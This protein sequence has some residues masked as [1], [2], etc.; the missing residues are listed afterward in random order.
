MVK[1]DTGLQLLVTCWYY[2]SVI[3]S[4]LPC[5]ISPNVVRQ[6]CP[7]STSTAWPAARHAAARTGVLPEEAEYLAGVHD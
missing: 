5:S 2:L 7:G 6:Y 1:V 3:H 4:A